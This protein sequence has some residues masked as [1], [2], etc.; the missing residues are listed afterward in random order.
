MIKSCIPVLFLTLLIVQSGTDTLLFI[1]QVIMIS[2][3]QH[4]QHTVPC[5]DA[6]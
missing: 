1:K 2:P 5:S 3:V 6:R 4:L